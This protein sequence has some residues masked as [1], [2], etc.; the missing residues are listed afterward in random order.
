MRDAFRRWG[1][2]AD[3]YA[4]EV[5]EDLGDD[6]RPW[7]DP[8]RAKG[9]AVIFHYALPSPM[10]AAFAEHPGRRVLLHHNITPPEFF[11]GWDAELARICELGRR[12]LPALKD[13]AHLGLGDSE[14]NRRELEAAGFARTGVLPI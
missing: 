9:D 8:A 3:V 1:H 14:Y 12:E 7:S 13:A 6:G 5:D 11:V 10:T 4:L 2:E